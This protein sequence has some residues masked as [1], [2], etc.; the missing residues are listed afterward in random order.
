M[1]ILI[2]AIV[3]IVGFGFFLYHAFDLE[4]S[5]AGIVSAFFV[6]FGFGIMTGSFIFKYIGG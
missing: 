6:I 2:G 3:V 5:L 4:P 1:T